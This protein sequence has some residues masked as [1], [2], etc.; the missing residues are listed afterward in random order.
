MAET[1]K[2]EIQFQDIKYLLAEP[3]TVRRVCLK[4]GISRL[5]VTKAAKTRTRSQVV[6]GSLRAH[7]IWTVCVGRTITNCEYSSASRSLGHTPVRNAQH[8]ISLDAVT[9]HSYTEATTPNFRSRTGCP[10]TIFR[11]TY[12]HVLQKNRPRPF[13]SFYILHQPLKSRKIRRCVH[14]IGRAPTCRICHNVPL[15]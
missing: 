4:P 1:K 15:F 5:K 9:N 3:C 13:L 10:H 7:R 8:V 6:V 12:S 2:F 14:P 11:K